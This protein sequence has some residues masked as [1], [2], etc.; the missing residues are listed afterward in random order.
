MLKTP[1]SNAHSLVSSSGV[2]D[3]IVLP[4]PVKADSKATPKKEEF[5]GN[6]KRKGRGWKGSG[7]LCTYIRDGETDG[8]YPNPELSEVLMTFPPSYTDLNVLEMPSY[9]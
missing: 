9:R 7:N 3:Y 1:H 6:F 4:T 2:G 5:F 8:I